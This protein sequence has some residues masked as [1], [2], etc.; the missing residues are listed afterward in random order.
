MQRG[1]VKRLRQL[2]PTGP[3]DLCG[4]NQQGGASCCAQS[5]TLPQASFHDSLH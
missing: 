5:A 2:N 1:M 3:H 4:A